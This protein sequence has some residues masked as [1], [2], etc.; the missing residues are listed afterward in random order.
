MI[1]LVCFIFRTYHSMN[2]QRA[3]SK[4]PWRQKVVKYGRGRG[5]GIT[6]GEHMFRPLIINSINRLISLLYL[7][8]KSTYTVHPILY[9]F[10]CITAGKGDWKLSS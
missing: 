6:V 4:P 10:F 1:L 5:F 2:L 7:D 3:I 9:R 8:R